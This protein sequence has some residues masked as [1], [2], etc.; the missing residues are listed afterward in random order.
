[1]IVRYYPGL[2]IYGGPGSL[3]HDDF[4][5]DPS[6]SKAV[7]PVDPSFLVVKI[8]HFNKNIYLTASLRT[9]QYRKYTQVVNTVKHVLSS[10]SK[11]TKQRS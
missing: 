2:Q 11:K 6:L 8:F 4:K 7:G 5:Y 1:M 3:S 10:H 9:P